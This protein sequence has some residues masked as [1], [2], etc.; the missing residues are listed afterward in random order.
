MS[1]PNLEKSVNLETPTKTGGYVPPEHLQEYLVGFVANCA[2]HAAQAGFVGTKTIAQRVIAEANERATLNDNLKRAMAQYDLT[3]AAV[4]GML[5]ALLATPVTEVH[6]TDADGARAM[7]DYEP[8]EH[9]NL[10]HEPMALSMGGI[11]IDMSGSVL[12]RESLAAGQAHLHSLGLA[13]F[14]QDSDFT[15]EHA[16]LTRMQKATVYANVVDQLAPE[17]TLNPLE[18]AEL[19]SLTKGYVE[20]LL[21][22]PGDEGMLRVQKSCALHSGSV[23][24]G[25]STRHGGYVPCTCAEGL[26]LGKALGSGASIEDILAD[27]EELAKAGFRYKSKKRGANGKWLYDYGAG[28]GKGRPSKLRSKVAAKQAEKRASQPV[29]DLSH[30]EQSSLDF[31]AVATPADKTALPVTDL[32]T[33]AGAPAFSASG[34]FASRSLSGAEKAVSEFLASPHTSE[35]LKDAYDASV[36]TLLRVQGDTNG[37][38]FSALVGQATRIHYALREQRASERAAEK[39]AARARVRE[40]SA[41]QNRGAKVKAAF[42]PIAASGTPRPIAPADS[43]RGAKAKAQAIRAQVKK[44]LGLSAKHVS[45]RSSAGSVDITVKVPGA[46]KSVQAIAAPH[47]AVSRD[48]NG[49]ILGGGNT[50]VTVRLDSGLVQPIVKQL[51][52]KIS[53]IAEDGYLKLS[54]KVH[55]QREPHDRFRIFNMADGTGGRTTSREAFGPESAALMIAEASLA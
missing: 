43:P 31:G 12:T 33:P 38:T 22:A 28:Y 24:D 15:Q 21:R 52:P 1:T 10:S 2:S 37:E 7:G 40:Q 6:S 17:Q 20:A 46:L 41:G 34:A 53:A 44:D 39:K 3:A 30:A 4:E 49:D 36:D 16:P 55:V 8:K 27:A 25:G 45:V 19:Q 9:L 42:Q 54:K 47:E 14:N 18:A 23:M 13:R 48:T 35:E 26:V 29:P 50:Y 51:A 5:D 32:E 11:P